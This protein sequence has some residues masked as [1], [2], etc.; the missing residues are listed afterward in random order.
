MIFLSSSLWFH[1]SCV[2]LKKIQS[3]DLKISLSI[4]ETN[5]IIFLDNQ[6]G[7]DRLYAYKSILN[8]ELLGNC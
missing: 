4:S 7:F 2:Y 6:N 3:G 8:A 1:L 5:Q